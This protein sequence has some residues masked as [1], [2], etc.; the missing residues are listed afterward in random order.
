MTK[1]NHY[2]QG[3]VICLLLFVIVRSKAD[4]GITD[5]SSL[6]LPFPYNKS[7]VPSTSSH[8]SPVGLHS[9]SNRTAI[10]LHPS[11]EN[12]LT[13][14]HEKNTE[15]FERLKQ[16]NSYHFK[17]IEKVFKEK[18]IPVELKY[19][20]VVESKLRS[21]A[22][23]SAGAAGMWQLMPATARKLGLKISNNIDDR[24]NTWKSSHAAARY[25]KKLYEIFDDW[26]L[27]IAAYNGGP[28]LVYTA[29]KKSGSRSFWQLQYFLPRETRMHVKKF[30]AT[31]Y[32]FEGGGSL[33]TIGKQEADEYLSKNRE[34]STETIRTKKDSSFMS[35]QNES[36]PMIKWIAII[37]DN[38]KLS[39]LLK[40]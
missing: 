10:P 36:I 14:Y 11:M 16:K 12:F 3:I 25:L 17:T 9:L 13:G 18:G 26:L 34:F 39:L 23:S 28:G 19:L 6:S 5:M 35:L 29:I 7:W 38:R 33:V 27:A 8:L 24:T 4:S 2:K 21:N 22:I 15:L 40:K 20:A 32:Y 37:T 30:I 1:K 31:H